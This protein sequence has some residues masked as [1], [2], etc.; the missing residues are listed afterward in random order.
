MAK[1]FHS[2]KG[3][4]SVKVESF[5]YGKRREIFVVGTFK[6]LYIGCEAPR[7]SV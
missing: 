5:R 7:F 3:K 1:L 6:L 4:Q 2:V